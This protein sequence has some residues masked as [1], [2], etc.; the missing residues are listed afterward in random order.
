MPIA[1]PMNLT[2]IQGHKCVSNV[3]TFELAVAYIG[4][5]LSYYIQTWHDG[6]LVD[7]ICAHARVDD[8]G[9]DARS[10]WGGKGKKISVACSR[11]LNKA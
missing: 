7:V 5:Y 2:V 8:L 6:R 1:R 10:Q 9:L 4:Q 11:Q 3:T